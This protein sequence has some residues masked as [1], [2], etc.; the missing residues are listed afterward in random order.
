MSWFKPPLNDIYAGLS[1]KAKVEFKL[2]IFIIDGLN[3]EFFK[4]ILK[5]FI[6]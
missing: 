2:V 1:G 3:L 6:I 4:S 5:F